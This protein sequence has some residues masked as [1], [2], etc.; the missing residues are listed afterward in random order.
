MCRHHALCFVAPPNLLDYLVRNG[1]D[2]TRDS[3]MRTLAASAALRAQRSVV[4]KVV[5]STD[6]DVRSLG[7]MSAPVRGQRTVYD[8]AHGGRNALPGTLAREEGDTA[9]ADA[10]VN[11]AFDGAG[12][13]YT[14]Y[15]EVYGRDSVDGAGAELVSTVHYGVRF[16]NAL[17]N[18][19]QMVYG[20]GG[21]RIFKEG[22]LTKALDVIAHELSHGVTQTRPAWS[23]ASSP[24]R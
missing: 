24:A 17:W 1:D 4:G 23:T 19:L 12:A 13:T 20:D 16:E 3:V 11:E 9:V 7:F 22:H 14:F 8:V 15:K 6:Q 5:A 21:G 18:G 10:A 2:E